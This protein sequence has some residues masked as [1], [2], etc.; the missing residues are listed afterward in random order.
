[1]FCFVRIYA[2]ENKVYVSD[3]LPYLLCTLIIQLLDIQYGEFWFE[4]EPFLKWR[5]VILDNSLAEMRGRRKC[6]YFLQ[7][8]SI[9]KP[10]HIWKLN[11]IK[12]TY[13]C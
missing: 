9:L 6:D 7:L 13:S 10:Y 11:V 3:T 1:M 4:L 2:G 12:I 8:L 5:K